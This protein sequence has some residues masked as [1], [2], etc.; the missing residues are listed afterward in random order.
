MTGLSVILA[1]LRKLADLRP[2]S[3]GRFANRGRIGLFG[4]V[5]R[6]GRSRSGH[7]LTGGPAWWGSLMCIER[8]A[9]R[10]C[11]NR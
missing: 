11:L 5:V 3:S 2:A 6:F 9:P 8:E 10:R 1:Y 4:G 7:Q